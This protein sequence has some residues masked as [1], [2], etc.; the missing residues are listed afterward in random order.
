[1]KKKERRERNGGYPIRMHDRME[2][3]SETS[4]SMEKLG[5][6]YLTGFKTLP[7]PTKQVEEV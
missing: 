3:D 6:P 5:Y 4:H 7:Q 2:W 1:M